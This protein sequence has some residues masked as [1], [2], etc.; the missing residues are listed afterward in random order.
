MCLG[1]RAGNE[2]R[3]KSI[4]ERGSEE[5]RATRRTAARKVGRERR[6]AGRGEEPRVKGDGYIRGTRAIL[7]KQRR[8]LT[9]ARAVVH[10]HT[11]ACPRR[12]LPQTSQS[13]PQPPIESTPEPKKRPPPLLVR[14]VTR[15]RKSVCDFFVSLFFLARL[16]AR[17][18]FRRVERLLLL[19]CLEAHACV[20]SCAYIQRHLSA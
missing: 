3:H 4:R 5:T 20:D 18:P 19:H 16:E 1:I 8:L 17:P 2:T 11:H 9:A 14:C 13:S 10:T 7:I 12:K 15:S 6:E